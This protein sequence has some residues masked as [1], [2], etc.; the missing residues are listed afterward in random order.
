MNVWTSMASITSRQQEIVELIRASGFETVERMA[1]LFGVTPQTIR[2]DINALCDAHLL[3]RRHGG[4]ELIGAPAVNLPYGSRRIFNLEAK[5]AIGAEVA[6]MI[7]NR[8]SV[9]FGIGT[10]PE[11]VARALLNHEDLTVVTNNVNVAV[12]LSGNPSNRIIMPG[13]IMRLPDL[14]FLGPHVEEMFRNYRVDFGIFG[15]GGIEPDGAL[16][17]FDR[18]E[19][20]ARM[21]LLENCRL[22]ILVADVTKFGRL[23][24]AS[25]GSLSD[26][27]AI[28][29]D[30]PP[31]AEAAPM[32][33]EGPIAGR[34]SFAGKARK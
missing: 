25:G 27:R 3:R 16:V 15:V 14:D 30:V 19:V 20:L 1:D 32:L 24:P 34:V 11:I 4:A 13:G 29:V 18:A 28:V 33:F 26:A 23:A 8:A 5:M 7:P 21:A 2:R 22:S 6:A 17:D 12:A 31:E 10:T 9:S